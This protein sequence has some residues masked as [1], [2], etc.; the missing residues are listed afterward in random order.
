M[1][2]QSPQV[3]K[4]IQTKRSILKDFRISPTKEELKKLSLCT[5]FSSAD[6]ETKNII[7]RHWNMPVN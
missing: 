7:K 4:Y 5:T 2:S 3:I 1:V 6:Y